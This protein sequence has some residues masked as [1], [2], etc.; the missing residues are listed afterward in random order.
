MRFDGWRSPR[1]PRRGA[2]N[3][4]ALIACTVAACAST[5]GLS[6]GGADVQTP[7]PGLEPLPPPS[8]Q[9]DSSALPI[10]PDASLGCS[11]FDTSAPPATAPTDSALAFLPSRLLVRPS[12]ELLVVGASPENNAI[13]VAQFDAIGRVDAS[14]GDRGRVV[15]PA[16]TTTERVDAALASDGYLVIA[17]GMAESGTSRRVLLLRLN[18]AGALDSEFGDA[19][20]VLVDRGGN[21]VATGV[22]IDGSGNI[23]VVGHT[24]TTPTESSLLPLR[25]TQRGALV[26]SFSPRLQ[27]A[28]SPATFA[29]RIAFDKEGR[30]V[31]SALSDD[32]RALG[33]TRATRNGEL[34]AAFGVAGQAWIRNRTRTQAEALLPLADGSVLL[35][36]SIEGDADSDVALFRLRPDGAR[37]PSFCGG[38]CVSDL[39]GADIAFDAVEAEAGAVYVVGRTERSTTEAFIA[40]Y[41][42]RG[43]LDP[44]FGTG[45]LVRTTL[46]GL[47]IEGFRAVARRDSALVLLGAARTAP[48]T[49]PFP[50]LARFCP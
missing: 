49:P 40:R 10:G 34:D 44:S 31:W 12:G 36:G 25:F 9:A 7:A 13:V 43:A 38:V 17:G 48:N 42:A 21:D 5:E 46:G 14:F 39:G 29:R 19:G 35:V 16:R 47:R 27:R 22:A 15:I 20:R 24:Q 8:S 30:L 28:P 3:W 50:T 2:S 33:V 6:G 18:R 26:T 41:D 11:G 23:F 32:G 37:D 4:L 1:R 45:G